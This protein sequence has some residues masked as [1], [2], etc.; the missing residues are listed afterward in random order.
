MSMFDRYP[1]PA[2][3]IPDNRPKCCKPFKLDI[4]AGETAEHSF[5]IPF[6]VE[7]SCSLVAVIYKL[8]LTDVLIKTS[9]ELEIQET[10]QGNSIITCKLS[11]EETSIFANTLLDARVQIKFYMVNDT[12]AYS[13]IYNVGLMTALDKDRTEPEPV[14][15]QPQPGVLGG[16][17][18]TE[19]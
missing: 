13:E 15:P 14:P 7:E 4:M 18:Y 16:L 3:Y 19:D 8:G 11:E 12:I 6:N 17:G 1:Q 9:S 10:E 2:D 5:E